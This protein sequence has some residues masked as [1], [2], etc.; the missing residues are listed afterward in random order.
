M[1]CDAHQ[2]VKE[3]GPMNWT[4]A[5]LELENGP[6]STE[7]TELNI[8]NVRGG[9]FLLQLVKQVTNA[10]LIATM[11]PD[12][13][14][15]SPFSWGLH[16]NLYYTSSYL[17]PTRVRLRAYP[18]DCHITLLKKSLGMVIRLREYRSEITSSLMRPEG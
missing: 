4:T 11:F 6:T 14:F 2:W 13:F 5:N 3:L 15:L 16:S 10:S 17:C 18:G 1:L 9:N 8:L 7:D 12:S